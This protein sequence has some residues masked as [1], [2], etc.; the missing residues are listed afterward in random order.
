MDSVIAKAFAAFEGRRLAELL[1]EGVENEDAQVVVLQ[2]WEAMDANE[3]SRWSDLEVDA[4][5]PEVLAPLQAEPVKTPTPSRARKK[6]PV[7]QENRSAEA[8]ESRV[9]A[10]KPED[11]KDD[12]NVRRGCVAPRSLQPAGD[13]I[14]PAQVLEPS[15]EPDA[16]MKDLHE[17]DDSQ[18]G[19]RGDKEDES[20]RRQH[21]FR[22]SQVVQVGGKHPDWLTEPAAVA[23]ISLPRLSSDELVFLPRSVA[24]EGRLSSVQMESVAYAARRF[25]SYLPSGARAGYYL[26]DG[27]GCG[28]GRIIA[29]LIWHL[30]NSGAKRHVWLSSHLSLGFVGSESR[31][32]CEVETRCQQRP[33]GGCNER[34]SRPRSR[35]AAF[36]QLVV[37]GLWTSFGSWSGC[38][39]QR[40][41]LRQLPAPRCLQR[42]CI[43]CAH[44]RDFEAWSAR[45]LA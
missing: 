42:R 37:Y 4:S 39:R 41:H 28:K 35:Q 5:A 27:T 38:R 1:S 12:N 16:D 2:Q 3:R 18:R 23:E 24:E 15:E 13:W 10:L 40:G 25:R 31:P 22:T 45:R 33:P 7:S 36:V 6:R 29:A 44:A 19:G 20:E 30:W 17:Q 34:F 26:G 8:G 32:D 9:K 43:R 11:H 14:Y 21:A